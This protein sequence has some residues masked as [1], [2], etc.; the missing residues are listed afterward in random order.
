MNA[1]TLTAPAAPHAPATTRGDD[2]AE[3]RDR[4]NAEVR[5]AAREPG[6]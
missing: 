3:R 2:A 5:A 1:T 4:I 6:W